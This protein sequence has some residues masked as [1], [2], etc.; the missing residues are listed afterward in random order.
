M[1]IQFSLNFLITFILL[2]LYLTRLNYKYLFDQNPL[3]LGSKN[4]TKTGSTKYAKKIKN[5]RIITS[6]IKITKESKKLKLKLVCVDTMFVMNEKLYFWK[7]TNGKLKYFL[8]ISWV[9]LLI[10]RLTINPLT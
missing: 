9:V 4:K 7:S 1:I 8:K 10:K 5:I 2:Y 3:G 6:L